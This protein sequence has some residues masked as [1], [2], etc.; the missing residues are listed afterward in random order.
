[1][2]WITA[3]TPGSMELSDIMYSAIQAVNVSYARSMD[4]SLH[5]VRI[6]T[7][8]V[9]AAGNRQEKLIRICGGDAENIT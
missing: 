3:C 9:C 5:F 4:L 7:R 2:I 8:M 6:C 1:M